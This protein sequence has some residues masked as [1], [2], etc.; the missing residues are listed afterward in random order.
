M[1]TQNSIALVDDEPAFL[2]ETTQKLRDRGFTVRSFRDG[3]SVLG[4]LEHGTAFD[5][6]VADVRMPGMTGLDLQTRLREMGGLV[7]LI[8]FTGYGEI[9]IAV[10]AMK[11]G[12]AD[13][14]GKP[15]DVER[16]DTSIRTAVQLARQKRSDLIASE[17]LAARVAQLTDRHRQVLDLMV[18]GLTS[19][20]IASSLDI[21]HR[22]VENYR[23]AIMDRIGVGNIAQLVRVML[24][25]EDAR[26][27]VGNTEQDHVR[28]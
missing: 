18:K 23:A 13:F 11:A 22:T 3:A 19:K 5:C 8:L 16:L 6:I 1:T 28:R 12:V 10:Q 25:L 17:A 26:Q 9:D 15:I 4:E 14:L 7:P 21:N 2:F 20:Q 24:R 27:L